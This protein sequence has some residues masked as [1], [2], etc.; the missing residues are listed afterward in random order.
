MLK[1]P[2]NEHHGSIIE[3]QSILSLNISNNR[4]RKELLV[5]GCT[6]YRA[7]ESSPIIAD[8]F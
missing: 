4:R 1:Q 6:R 7:D 8:Y 5:A 2:S 3:V